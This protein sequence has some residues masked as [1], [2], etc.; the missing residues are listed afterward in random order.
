MEK[1]YPNHE[2]LN[3]IEKL[4]NQHYVEVTWID[5]CEIRDATLKDVEENYHTEV[6]AIGRFYK[7]KDDYLIIVAEVSQNL[8]YKVLCI[9]IGTIKKI[10]ILTKKPLKHPL[11]ITK[12]IKPL[13][14]VYVFV[15]NLN[16][17]LPESK[18]T[19]LF[20]IRPRLTLFKEG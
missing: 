13:K 12:T 19:V 5:A 11:R 1:H 17:S 16:Y 10:K 7:V 14:M 6:R 9:P 15:K 3:I 20:N 2:V 4:T 18:N 8:G